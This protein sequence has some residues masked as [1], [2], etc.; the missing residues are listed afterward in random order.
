M[1]WQQPLVRHYNVARKQAEEHS[2]PAPLYMCSVNY[3]PCM[4]MAMALDLLW[5]SH[6]LRRSWQLAPASTAYYAL[7]L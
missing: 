1:K 7:Q 4:C 5:G 2:Y 6:C 3:A